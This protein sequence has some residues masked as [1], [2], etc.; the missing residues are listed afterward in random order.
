MVEPDHLQ[1]IGGRA[2]GRDP[3]ARVERIVAEE[4]H[5]QRGQERLARAGQAA[6]PDHRPRLRRG[7]AP[8]RR[9]RHGAEQGSHDAALVE[10]EHVVHD[11]LLDLLELFIGQATQ[12]RATGQLS[13]PARSTWATPCAGSYSW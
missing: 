4:V 2:P 3:T 9:Q 6:E 12:A 11:V 13:Q 5:D 1:V 8:Q 10:P 7:E